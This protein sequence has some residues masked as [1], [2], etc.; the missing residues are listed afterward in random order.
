MLWRWRETLTLEH[1]IE[2]RAERIHKKDRIAHAFGIATFKADQHR[3]RTDGHTKDNLSQTVRRR[4]H[5]VGSHKEST[6]HCATRKY[7]GKRIAREE[8]FTTEHPG[9]QSNR[10]QHRHGNMPGDI[11]L[12]DQEDSAQK[13]QESG[14]FTDAARLI[15]DKEAAIKTGTRTITLAKCLNTLLAEHTERSSRSHGIRNGHSIERSDPL[16]SH[17]K[18]TKRGRHDPSGRHRNRE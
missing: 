9:E 15:A 3:D 11:F 12:E 2:H 1:V 10:A 16:T 7:R 18:I 14:C 5:I 6:E 17:A 4:G 8:R 13:Q